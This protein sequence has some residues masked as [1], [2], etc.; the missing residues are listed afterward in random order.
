LLDLTRPEWKGRVAMAKPLFGTT[1]T[2][3]ACLFQAWG[4]EKARDYFERLKANDV[5]I[6]AGNKQVAVGVGLGQFDAGL[7]DTDDAL[8]EI[9]QGRPV[10][11]I[12]L[13]ADAAEGSGLGTLFIPN[14]IALIKNCPHPEDAKKLIDYLLS[15][16]VEAK[17]A[18]GESRQIPLNPQVKA[19][20]P[21]VMLPARTARPFPV[22]FEK[23]ADAWEDSQKF[24]KDAFALR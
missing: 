24:L 8:A 1:A 9:D 12:F 15:P 21:A 3:A 11:M 7:T 5:Q 4:P 10:T 13:D 19:D 23:A 22:D 2:H 20:M 6:V 16:E 17:L 18:Q 14:T